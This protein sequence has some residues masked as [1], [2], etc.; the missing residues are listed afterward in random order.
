MHSD[1]NNIEIMINDQAD[2]V[3]K[4]FLIHLKKNIL[5]S[6]KGSGFVLDYVQSLYHKCHKTNPI[7]GG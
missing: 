1:T 4:E 7:C 5:E 6:M 3:I 2:E